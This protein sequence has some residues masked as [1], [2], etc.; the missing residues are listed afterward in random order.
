M[1]EQRPESSGKSNGELLAEQLSFEL[2]SAWR[3]VSPE[4]RQSVTR[5]AA[6]Y[7]AFLD[8]AKTAPLCIEKCA[9]LLRQNQFTGLDELRKNG[10]QIAPGTKW[11]Q[12]RKNKS[13]VCAIAGS[14][15]LEEGVSIIGAHADSP[16]INVKTNPLYE[17]SGLAFFDTQYYG[18]IKYYQWTAVPLALHGA[19]FAKDGTKKQIHAGGKAGDPVFCVTDLLPHLARDQMK[20]NAADFIDGEGLDILAGSQPFDDGKVSDA[21]KLA[22]LAILHEQYGITAKSFANAELSFVP[23]FNARDVG[24]DRSMIGAYGHDDKSGVY[25]A[26]RALIGSGGAVPQKTVMCFITDKEEAVAYAPEI[27]RFKNMLEVIGG[28]NV[29]KILGKSYMLSIDV[30]AAYDP[31]YADVHDKN[32]DSF[33]GRGIALTK[34]GTGNYADMDFCQT[35]Q[36]MLDAHNIQWQYGGCGKVGK[37]G[38]STIAAAFAALGI[39]VLDCGVPVL[40]MHSPFEVISKIDLWA[41]YRGCQA[42]F[43]QYKGGAHD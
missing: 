22:A 31:N 30:N 18:A 10:R 39:E 21:V 4:E 12:N 1:T 42:F 33:L 29:S 15:P 14:L 41:A 5:F 9:E 34:S 32:N 37:G 13:L 3:T 16:C 43:T 6:D 35:I 23:A 17:D 26:L 11:Y 7:M 38:G 19:V 24:F 20:K 28:G 36:N 2:K 40:S 25:T 27:Q 8:E